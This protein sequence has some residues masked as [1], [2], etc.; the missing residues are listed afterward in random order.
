WSFTLNGGGIRCSLAF[1]SRSIGSGRIR[2]CI[3]SRNFGRSFSFRAGF[4]SR[5]LLGGRGC[6][7]S[8]RSVGRSL[9]F[10]LRGSVSRCSFGL[11]C[12]FLRGSLF[13]CRLLGSRLLIGRRGIRR[14]FLGWRLFRCRSLVSGLL[15]G[16]LFSRF[17]NRRGFLSW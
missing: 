9:T 3:L 7:I 4:Y 5:G 1:C 15:N 10:S 17:F 11:S 13:S 2:R 16:R 8:R 6:L 12:R 14:S